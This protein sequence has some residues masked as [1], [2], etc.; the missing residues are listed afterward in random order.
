MFGKRGQIWVETVIYTLIGLVIIAALLAV[1]TPKLNSLRD[2]AIIANTIVSLNDFNTQV[3]NI[4]TSPGN[5]RQI[6]FSVKKGEYTIDTVNELLYYTLKDTNYLLSQLNETRRSGD[7]T[8]L[9]I[10]KSGKYNI[11][12][13]LNYSSLNL[14]Y[15]GEDKDRVLAPASTT[16]NFLIEYM[17]GPD[18]RV[19]IAQ[20]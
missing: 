5:K 19:N 4:L 18:K 2:K 16:Y 13:T 14:T 3:S 12:L 10:P 8:I 20:I 11:I 17:G 9:T 1:M 6:S 15:N 7:L